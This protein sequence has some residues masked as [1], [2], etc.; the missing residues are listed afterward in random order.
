MAL[1]HSVNSSEDYTV[2]N[3]DILRELEGAHRRC[4]EFEQNNPKIIERTTY[5]D[6][7]GSLSL[8]RSSP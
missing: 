7:Y 6:Q 3:Y 5:E 1:K 4:H 2:V 8:D